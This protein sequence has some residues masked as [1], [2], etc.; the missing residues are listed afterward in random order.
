MRGEE[1]H[2]HRSVT[3]TLQ[4]ARSLHSRPGNAQDTSQGQAARATA[5]HGQDRLSQPRS[6]MSTGV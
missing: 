2:G 5:V 4:S 1:E 3:S 6:R